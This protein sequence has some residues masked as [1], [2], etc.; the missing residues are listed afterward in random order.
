MRRARADVRRLA[1]GLLAAARA[2]VPD[3]RAADRLD[4]ARAS[5]SPPPRAAPS[6]GSR[7]RSSTSSRPSWARCC[8]SSP[9]RAS[10]STAC[11]RWGATTTARI[12]LLG[13]VPDDARHGRARPRLGAGLRRRRRSR[14]CSSPARRGGTS[15]RWPRWSRS[16]SRSSL[17]AAPAVGRRGAQALPGG[18]PDGVPAPVGR[19]GRRGLPAAAVADRHRLGREDRPRRRERH[20]DRRSN[21]L[22]EHHTD[23]IFAV[24]GETYGFA[25]AALVLSLYALLIW[26][27][28][29]ILTIAKNLYGA[30][31]AG[32]ITVMLLFQL[33]VNVG[34]NVGIMP[35]TGVTGPAPEL[36]RLVDARHVPGPRPP[37][38]GPRAGA[39][40]GSAARDGPPSSNEDIILKKQV[41]VTVDR[42]ETRVAMLEAPGDPAPAEVTTWRRAPRRRATSPRATASPRSTSSAAAAARSSATSTRARSTTSCPASRRRS[43]TSASTRTASCTSTRSC[44][45]ASSRSSAAAARAA[46][47]SPTCSSRGRRSSSRSSRTR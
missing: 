36:R 28:L 16:R 19:S 29:H 15:P 21:F 42:G 35:I 8:W 38:L 31:I 43:S 39:R 47:A 40:D 25:G 32:G 22:P 12:M 46:R 41:L 14:S 26:R 33:F 11:A 2:A 20:A 10:S 13:A 7:C 6:A 9:C 5:R 18:P 24:V 23:F 30:L 37:A 34:M 3:L 44:C 27:G 1:A 4:P 17:V 45:R